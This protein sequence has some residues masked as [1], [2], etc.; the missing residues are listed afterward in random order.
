M[1]CGRAPRL[2][3][4]SGPHPP[5]Q[6]PPSHDPGSQQA[7]R[8]VARPHWPADNPR[9][10][11]EQPS[12]GG[13]PT[14]CR[15]V[16][17]YRRHGRDFSRGYE[18]GRSPYVMP[19]GSVTRTATVSMAAA[20]LRESRMACAG[21]PQAAPMTWPNWRVSNVTPGAAAPWGGAA[22]FACSSV[23]NTRDGNAL[24]VVQGDEVTHKTRRVLHHRD[25]VFVESHAWPRL[26]RGC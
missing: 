2:G 1:T 12:G 14:S 20:K 5:A 8:V 3:V 7:S 11:D 6:P 24:T 4:A 18:P 13:S 17:D 22:A 25:Y 21:R 19:L 10:P 23:S 9:T 26:D 15:L 16:T